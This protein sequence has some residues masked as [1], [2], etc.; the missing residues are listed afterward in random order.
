MR[1]DIARRHVRVG[2]D[3][4]PIGKSLALHGARPVHALAHCFARL[5]AVCAGQGAILHRGNFEMDI[6]P[7]EE[8]PRDA[9]E[10]AL[11]VESSAGA[12]VMWVAKPA[13]G[14]GIHRRGEH[15]ARRIRETHRRARD[16]HH[17]VFHRLAQH[18]EHV[19]AEFRQLVEKEHSAM[20]QAH[21]TGTRIGAA[22][23]QA[24]IRDRVMRRSK[25]APRDER[26]A[27]G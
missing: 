1:P 20:R 12:G 9:R 24:G 10:I 25:R 3:P 6:D 8:R 15:E 11:H 13:A 7:I 22:T 23:D 5:S 18:L 27:E 14:T 17:A 19:L 21:L 26:L 16:G 4:R 2:V